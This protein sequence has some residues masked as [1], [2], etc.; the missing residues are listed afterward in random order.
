MRL[1]RVVFFLFLGALLAGA[2]GAC[3]DDDDEGGDGGAETAGA[4][5]PAGGAS[6]AE[7]DAADFSFTPNE[8]TVAA[9]EEVTVVLNNTG[10]APHTLTVYSDEEFTEPVPGADTGTVNL[11]ES[12]DFAATFEAGEYYFQCQFHLSQMQG[13]LKAE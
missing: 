9:G 11:D 5:T 6:T 4:T 8:F 1:F 10:D 12:G 13:E 3:G 2:V 7:V